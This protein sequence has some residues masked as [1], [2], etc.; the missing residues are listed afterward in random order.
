MGRKKVL[1]K[2][3]QR[4]ENKKQELAKRALE[5]NDA[6]EVRSLNEKMQDIIDELSDIKEE[7]AAIE[8]EE[9]KVIVK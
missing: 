3:M 7:I 2:R 1:E 6:N 5:S 4:L 8:E 9:G